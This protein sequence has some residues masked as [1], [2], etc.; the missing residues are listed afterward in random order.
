MDA[1]TFPDTAERDCPRPAA[2]AVAS[3][4]WQE[5][6][7]RGNASRS[8]AW[9]FTVEAL[10]TQ[11]FPGLSQRLHDVLGEDGSYVLDE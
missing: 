2:S 8:E 3:Q 5:E 9:W 6:Q 1:V 7:D 11:A 4:S 10:F